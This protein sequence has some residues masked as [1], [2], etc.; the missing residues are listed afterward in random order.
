VVVALHQCTGWPSCLTEVLAGRA[1]LRVRGV[2][3]GEELEV[4]AALVVSGSAH[5]EW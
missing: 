1:V 4:D 3:D 5:S 2:V